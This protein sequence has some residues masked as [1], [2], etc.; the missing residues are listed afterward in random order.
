MERS[1]AGLAGGLVA[2]GGEWGDGGDREVLE[3]GG[4]DEGDLAVVEEA[5]LAGCG[6]KQV[7]GDGVGLVDRPVEVAVVGTALARCSSSLSRAVMRS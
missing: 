3:A 4:T 5:G 7:L 2:H 6:P 1:L